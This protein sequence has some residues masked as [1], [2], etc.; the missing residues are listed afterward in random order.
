MKEW[1]GMKQKRAIGMMGL[2]L[3]GLVVAG[4]ILIGF[5]PNVSMDYEGRILI[6]AL[7]GILTL[8]C[9]YFF[10]S[11]APKEQ[12]N[13]VLRSWMG[14]FFGLYLLHLCGLLF[15]GSGR[16][17]YASY[18]REAQSM[19]EYLSYGVNVVPF[20][21]ISSYFALSLKGEGYACL[22][23]LGNVLMFLPMGI[24][25]PCLFPKMRKLG[26]FLL[27]CVLA[28]LGAEV[29][30]VLTRTGS[31]DID[32]VILNLLGGLLGFFLIKGT[33]FRRR[34]GRQTI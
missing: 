25:L 13:R 34:A 10:Y 12:K 18:I 28:A 15:F 2:I 23:L 26:W 16:S 29:L 8:Y 9:G 17:V 30:Q 27:A 20:R 14:M 21:T 3:L 1:R 4:Q 32:D 22:N 11:A 5:L 31:G 7:E 6:L 33:V 24:F 19:E